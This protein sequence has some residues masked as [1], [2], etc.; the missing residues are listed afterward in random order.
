[1]SRLSGLRPG[2]YIIVLLLSVPVG[3][4]GYLRT[5]GVFACTADGYKVSTYEYMAYCNAAG[6]GEYDHGAFWF[7]LEPE[8]VRYAADAAVLFLGSSRTEFAFSTIATDRWFASAGVAHY[9]LGFTNVENSTFVAP[10]LARLKPR[11]KVYVINVDQ[12]FT[13]IESDVGS[14]ILHDPDV[15]QRYREKKLWQHVHRSVCSRLRAACGHEFAYFR[16]RENGHWVTRG[17]NRE[18]AAPVADGPIKDQ[19]H[20]IQ[21]ASLAKQFIANLPV[22]RSCVLL[23]IVPYPATRRAEAQALAHDLELKLV[24]PQPPDL[25]TFDGSHLDEDSAE[26]WSKAFY[27]IAGPR[28]K[29]CLGKQPDL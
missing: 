19:D 21:Y 8:A 15:G 29:A 27:E 17:R 20:W 25:R 5:L 1:M 2:L 12:F 7:N 16:A 10:L 26:R 14:E 3:Y 23:T 4:V 18:S 11:A 22:D 9:L 28:I 24:D 13:G 6:Y